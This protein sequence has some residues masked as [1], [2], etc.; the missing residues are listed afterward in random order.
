MTRKV[1]KEEAEKKLL[2]IDENLN[3]HVEWE[4]YLRKVYGYENHE[5]EEFKKDTSSEMTS[6]LKVTF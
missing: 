6:F 4:E 5:I 3:K 1:D 2:D